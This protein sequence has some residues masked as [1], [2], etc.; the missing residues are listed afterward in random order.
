M[1]A[2]TPKHLAT[3]VPPDK[4]FNYSSFPG[5]AGHEAMPLPMPCIIDNFRNTVVVESTVWRSSRT[6]LRRRK[7][8]LSL[9]LNMNHVPAAQ[10]VHRLKMGE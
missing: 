8:R 3:D 7:Q 2:A 9:A 10:E 1:L 6:Y 4:S 5:G